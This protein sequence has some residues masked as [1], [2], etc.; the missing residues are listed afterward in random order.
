MK[1]AC[2][3]E[4]NEH[5][6]ACLVPS[7]AKHTHL[8]CGRYTYFPREFSDLR[9]TWNVDEIVGLKPRYNIAPTK[10][11]PSSFKRTESESSSCSAGDRFRGGPK[12]RPSENRMINARGETLTEK[13]ALKDMLDQGKP[14]KEIRTYVDQ[15][16]SRYG[17]PTP[18]PPVPQNW[19]KKG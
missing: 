7:D 9:L 17:P 11:R 4:R 18:T 14:L 6:P 19:S 13:T 16:Y 3:C 10:K 2:T 1:G 12:T 15:T 8:M 5:Y